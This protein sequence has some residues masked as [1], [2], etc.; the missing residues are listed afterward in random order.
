MYKRQLLTRVKPVN[1]VMYEI[2]Y[3]PFTRA[4]FAAFVAALVLIGIPTMLVFFTCMVEQKRFRDGLRRSAELVK[5]RWHGALG[6]LFGVNALLLAGVVAL[7]LFLVFAAAVCVTLFVDSYAAMA[8]DVYKRQVR[9]GLIPAERIGCQQVIR[10]REGCGMKKSQYKE[11]EGYMLECM[12]DTVH[13][14]S[15]I[16]I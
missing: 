11:I 3:Q 7:H 5:G 12:N 13:D 14:L 15:L 9:G 10:K 4:A 16:H 8:V 1:F 6:L 2:W